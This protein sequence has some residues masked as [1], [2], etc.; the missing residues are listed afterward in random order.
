MQSL[1]AA[2]R[3]SRDV[4]L[5][6][7]RPTPTH[8]DVHAMSTIDPDTLAPPETAAEHA[9]DLLNTLVE[10]FLSRGKNASLLTPDEARA[11]TTARVSYQR[12]LAQR[13]ATTQEH[14]ERA[15]AQIDAIDQQLHALLLQRASVAVRMGAHK[16]QQREPE[17]RRPRREEQVLRN[18]LDAG[19][20]VFSDEELSH[21]FQAIMSSCLS[22]QKRNY[23][24]T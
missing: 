18:V 22:A 11:V 6:I 3:F 16:R 1:R 23:L 9:A 20:G 17:L 8:C 12:L 4:V 24:L 10:Q 7:P 19:T 2:A 13:R 15:R 5:G 14:I 21:V